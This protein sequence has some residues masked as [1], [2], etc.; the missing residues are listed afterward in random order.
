[1]YSVLRGY[2]VLGL[3]HGN[4]CCKVPLQVNFLDEDIC[5]AF[6][7][8]YL[9]KG[10]MI[11]LVCY[12]RSRCSKSCFCFDIIKDDRKAYV[13]RY[14]IKEL[15]GHFTEVVEKK[16]EKCTGIKQEIYC[17]SDKGKNNKPA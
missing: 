8:S 17:V 16:R 9:P 5:I 1:M 6:Y 11:G 2:G 13:K 14:F 4:T 15:H 12:M 10:V 3:R 7:E